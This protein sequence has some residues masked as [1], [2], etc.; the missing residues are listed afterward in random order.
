MVRAN[1][2]FLIIVVLSAVLLSTLTVCTGKQDDTAQAT[3]P[4]SLTE[5][6]PLT[7]RLEGGDTGLP[8]PFRHVPRGPG[9]SK[10]WI[11]YDSL[12]EKD[13]KQ[14]I[15]WLAARWEAQNDGTVYIFHIRENAVWHDNTPLTAEDVAF[16]FSYYKEHP[17]VY[18]E[19][20]AGG[21]YIV[22]AVKALDPYT[23]EISLNGFDTTYLTR[24]GYARI[25]P[26]HIW[27]NV[28]DP[29]SYT[30]EGATTGSGPYT[31]ETYNPQQGA[32]RYTAFESYWGPTPAV[33]A[34]EYVPVSDRI[35]A[36][37][38]NEIDLVNPSADMLP[39]YKN[40][41]A[42]TV[43]TNPSYHSYRL[44]MN[45]EKI[46]ELRDVRLRKAIAYGINRQELVDKAARGAALI[47]S[48]G[49]VPAESRWYNGDIEQ[50]H[51]DQ[52]KARGF[53]NGKTYSFTL[54]TDNSPDGINVAELIKLSLANIG[55]TVTVESA[56]TRTRDNA[57][58]TGNYELLLTNLGGMGGDPDY[59]R[60]VY[61][62]TS[63]IKGWSNSEISALLKAQ[64]SERDESVRRNIIFEL[65]RL[66][67]DEV[68]MILLHG[69][70]D[71]YVFRTKTYDR[72][73]FR[74]DHS[75]C[76]HNKLSYVTRN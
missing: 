2:R 17:P 27:E 45:M 55:I 39:K 18:N 66:I 23:V 7:L 3:M 6:K 75:K 76:D 30:G 57:M 33:S 19:L 24:I 11:L 21:N 51:Y 44:M 25:L 49:Y 47:S 65:Q 48:M 60:S 8:N 36:F 63:A 5:K 32:Y 40:D 71:N 54:L 59:L 53:L 69:A 46:P 34:I 68:P 4:E 26:K 61:G 9:M 13:E 29:A 20:S 12:L 15:P 50:Y 16:T 43:K 31:L 37:E 38:N 64:A 74:Y 56:E 14:D 35:L 62:E 70:V 28:D 22:T 58:N 72:W 42:Y 1:C 67:A 52:D 41:A 10:M 73:M